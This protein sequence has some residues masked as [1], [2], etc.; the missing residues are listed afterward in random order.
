MTIKILQQF[1]EWVIYIPLYKY[2][3]DGPTLEAAG[4]HVWTFHYLH[5]SKV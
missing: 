2:S 4:V 1:L 3:M 5:G